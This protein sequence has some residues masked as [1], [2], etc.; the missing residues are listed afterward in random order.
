MNKLIQNVKLIVNNNYNDFLVSL[1][2]TIGE[3]QDNNMEVE[4]QFSS[5]KEFYSALVLGRK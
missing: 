3:F 1:Q 2:K 4:I 5:G